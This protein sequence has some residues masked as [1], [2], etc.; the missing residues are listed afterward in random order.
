MIVMRTS[1]PYDVTMTG[2]RYPFDCVR[3]AGETAPSMTHSI[4][5]TPHCRATRLTAESI[6]TEGYSPSGM[7]TESLFTAGSEG[8][9]PKA[10]AA[11]QAVDALRGYVYQIMAAA[12]AWLDI[13]EKAR[14]F[15]EV[16]EDYAVVASGVLSAVQVK[17]T[18]VS[19]NVT[20]NTESIRDA[21]ANYVALVQNNPQLDVHLEYFTTSEIG[22]E[23]TS[24]GCPAGEPGLLYWRTAA[25]SGD[26]TPLRQQLESDKFSEDVRKFVKDRD[27]EAL[28][29]GLL[30]KIHWNCSTPDL[31]A[32]RSEFEARLIVVGWERFTLPAAEIPTIADLLLHRVL[33]KSVCTPPADRVLRRADLIKVINDYSLVSVPRSALQALSAASAGLGNRALGGAQ[34]GTSVTAGS[35]LWL[36]DGAS[37][38]TAR[39]HLRRTQCEA[40]IAEKL[41]MYGACFVTGTSGVGKT[42]LARAVAEKLGGRFVIVDFRNCETEEIISRLST[43]LSHLGGLGAQTIL[44]EDLN[45]F[46]EPQLALA[47]AQ[48]FGAMA[49]RA[50]AVVIT[51]YSSP[52][53]KALTNAGL[54]AGVEQACPYF[55]EQEAAQLVS[56]HGGDPSVWGK[57]AYVSGASGHPQLVHAFVAGMAARGWPQSAIRQILD[58]GLSTGDI[59]AERD[60]ARR[61][62]A[63]ALPDG[64]RELLYRLSLMIGN[65]DRSLAL[66]LASTPPPV[67]SPGESLDILIGPWVET[68][69]SGRYRISPLAAQF[70]KEM[71]A[72]A[73]Q[74]QIHFEIA[75]QLLSSRTIDVG[76]IDKIIVHA[77]TGKNRRI[78][79]DVAGKLG[80][81]DGSIINFLAENYSIVRLFTTDKPIYPE[82][83]FSSAMLRLAQFKVLA[84]GNDKKRIPQCVDALQRE[85]DLQPHGKLR[86]AFRLISFGAILNTLGIAN[87][88]D[89]WF[90]LLRQFQSFLSGSEVAKNFLAK[91]GKAAFTDAHVIP[92]FFA[93]GSANIKHV[94]TLERIFDQV[95]DIAPDE[96]E[97][98]FR[99]HASS[100]PDFSVLVNNPWLAEQ[101]DTLDYADAAE[102]YRRMAMVTASWG[103]RRLTLHCWIAQAIMFDEY[104]KDRDSALHVLAEAEAIW[105]P[106]VLLARARAKVYWRAQDHVKALSILR[107]IADV[108]GQDNVI[109]RAF[110]LREAAIS[111]AKTRDW[112]QAEAWFQEGRTAALKAEA[113]DMKL[114]AIGLGADAAVAAL[115]V[116]RLEQALKGVG[117]ALV[118]LEAIDPKS[119]LRAAYCHHV[120]RHI[121]LWLSS[122]IED[123]A[124]NVA[125][126][127]I[128]MDPGCCSNLEPDA[129]FANRPL[130]SADIAWYMLAQLDVALRTGLGYVDKIRQRMGDLS[131]PPLEFELGCKLLMRS[132][133]DLDCEG[134]ADRAW[135]FL[136]S[137]IG[138]FAYM[139]QTGRKFDALDPEQR[140]IPKLSLSPLD[141]ETK[142]LVDDAVLA[143]AIGCACKHSA[144]LLPVMRAAMTARFGE[145]VAKLEVFSAI[146][147]ATPIHPFVAQLIGG[148]LLFQTGHHPSPLNYCVSGIRS[149]QQADRSHMKHELIRMIAAWQRT[150]WTRIVVSETFQL[151]RPRLSVPEIWTAL[152]LPKDNEQFLCSLIL[153][154]ADATEVP[155]PQEMRDDYRSRA[156]IP[157]N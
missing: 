23:K 106:D 135:D 144:E 59:D 60:A 52:T 103:I 70:G 94:A 126:E 10:D 44:L 74:T 109:D 26:L 97:F 18:Q 115:E 129:S 39:L 101:R 17:D 80:G 123:R 93:I 116:G 88:L 108:V 35:S 76:D 6:R 132:I 48:I 21:I 141:D 128:S 146:T 62:I 77:M 24:L 87:Y 120:L 63:T 107:D 8:L 53:T 1:H 47:L 99:T 157:V 27:D 72:A 54:A 130:G 154:A 58:A 140:C 114:M 33:E 68:L 61:A 45:G 95:N 15:L 19:G 119:S 40:D 113:G 151:A 104:G 110:A 16:A 65:F 49:R 64:A 4:V 131:I 153:A 7:S 122:R 67:V 92:N 136:E 111:A 127:P 155:L 137:G 56:L 38:P 98:Y 86:E 124:V 75:D 5:P 25:R 11:R 147:G 41:R 145:E 12:L 20:L 105:G 91:T 22:K 79:A 30:R 149:L 148:L 57:L 96:R 42:L 143:F 78:L 34:V 134:F 3:A 36:A 46:N 125:G 37:L 102:R 121:V 32:L 138:A 100:T 50:I 117:D 133:Q 81:A 43:V 13:D 89:N 150:A 31:A 90:D 82:D 2:C 85:I 9:V 69:G 29:D 118:E 28:R 84:A 55:G 66:R 71:I 156:L 152:S 14:I 51:C 83:P 73:L 139:R 142:S 112:G